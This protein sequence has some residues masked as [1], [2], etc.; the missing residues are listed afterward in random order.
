MLADVGNIYG[1]T[2][3]GFVGNQ[4]GHVRWSTSIESDTTENFRVVIFSTSR[5]RR[6]SAARIKEL[7]VIKVLNVI[8]YRHFKIGV[9]Q[10]ASV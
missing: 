8:K 6:A 10:N 2:V 9:Q 1:S 5:L 3:R 7:R 4:Y